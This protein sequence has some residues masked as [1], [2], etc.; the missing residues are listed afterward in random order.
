MA[1]R[2]SRR[3]QVS[4]KTSDRVVRA[5]APRSWADQSCPGPSGT[6]APTRPSTV[7]STSIWLARPATVWL[8]ASPGP[9]AIH[10]MPVVVGSRSLPCPLPW[11]ALGQFSPSPWSLTTMKIV[12]S[13][14]RPRASS[15]AMSAPTAASK[16]RSPTR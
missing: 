11:T 7:G 13:A 3:I 2:S 9:V 4:M 1:A 12:F 16:R 8:R 5:T 10:G 15:P 6:G 14:V